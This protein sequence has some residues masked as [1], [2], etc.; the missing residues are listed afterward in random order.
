MKK[1]IE[2]TL[3]LFL[4]GLIFLLFFQLVMPAGL[5]NINNYFFSTND[6]GIKNYYTYLYY[7][8][9]DSGFHF[10]GMAYPYGDLITFTD[11][12]PLLVL[13]MKCADHM[14]FN[15][16]KYALAIFNGLLLIVFPLTTL[17]LYKILKHYGVSMVYDFLIALAI[18]FLNPQIGRLDAHYALAYSFV[19]PLF[20]L[21]DIKLNQSQK[22]W[23]W[24]T[25]IVVTVLALTFLHVYYLAVAL[26]FYTFSGIARVLLSDYT[27]RSLLPVAVKYIPVAFLPMAF[28]K[29]FMI[30]IDPVKDRV[31]F[32]FGFV[33]HRASYRSIFFSKNSPFD[34]LV[35]DL[36]KVG[37]F[38]PEGHVYL[39]VFALLF[40]AYALI[41][42]AKRNISAKK[43]DFDE[44]NLT[45][46]D[47]FKPYMVLAFLALC[48]AAAF[49]FYMPPF[50]RAVAWL[51]PLAQ[52][53]SPGRFAW[54]FFFLFN[55][56]F[57]LSLY[58][59][60]QQSSR[61]VA[62]FLLPAVLVIGLFEGI[63]MSSVKLGE[64]DK[65]KAGAIFSDND[66]EPSI[67]KYA[68]NTTHFQAM[69][70]FPFFAIGT[71]KA[72][73][74]G[75]NHIILQAMKTS[76][77]TGLPMVNYMMSRTSVS[78][79]LKIAQLTG[80]TFLPKGYI[81]TLDLNKPLLLM[82]TDSISEVE[83]EITRSATFLFRHND[84]S[85]Y[86]LYPG[87]FDS[88]QHAKT[89]QVLNTKWYP[90]KGNTHAFASDAH[91][92]FFFHKENIPLPQLADDTEKLLSKTQ[93]EIIFE[94][95][96]P[97]ADTLVISVWMRT[98]T[99]RYGFPQFKVT[100]LGA[101]GKPVF[102][103]NTQQEKGC[104]L[105]H[106]MKRYTC[107]FRPLDASH[108]VRIEA[109]GEK[110]NYSNLVISNA[111]SDII[112]H[113]GENNWYWNNYPAAVPLK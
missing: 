75:T 9:Y 106:N 24:I 31:G 86:R 70:A 107:R 96:L 16:G 43:W 10:S 5:S 92:V 113:D 8:K 47:T 66:L 26:I 88:I 112:F 80:N 68:L 79:G 28:F 30:V 110:Y 39:G 4:S 84:L 20:W 53:R 54:I 56:F 38:D 49:P 48:I 72:G 94:G 15:N 35:P 76:Y 73:W 87:I 12:Q 99:A 67:A 98:K 3:V 42:F 61:L 62:K 85:F 93:E 89:Q 58:R 46:N 13:F 102:Q 25:I 18:T 59:A 41:R 40:C 78:Q 64:L 97:A 36:I 55:V 82:T 105:Y 57:Y 111:S 65:T 21:M 69:V 104:E 109:D 32:P 34:F 11:N 23:R 7:L 29:A 52:F 83:K 27:K 22:S 50:D 108:T 14:G 17:M 95:T 63:R 33:F 44:L 103:F 101:D 71:E 1:F 6:D 90:V 91:P 100:E 45:G 51:T 74:D 60:R 37:K 77:H 81:S 19:I 2:A